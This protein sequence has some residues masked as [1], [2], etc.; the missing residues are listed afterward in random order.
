MMRGQLRH[1]LVLAWPFIRLV[2]LPQALRAVIPAFFNLAV[3]ILLN[4]TMIAAI[5]IFDLLNAANNAANDPF[6]LEKHL[7]TA[8]QH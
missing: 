6:W 5:A 2:V 1:L 4:S 8:P 3:E 7:R